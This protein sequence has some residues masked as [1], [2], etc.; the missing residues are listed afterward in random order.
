SNG[1]A[2]FLAK[3]GLNP[4]WAGPCPSRNPCSKLSARTAYAASSG[5]QRPL[6]K[7]RGRDRAGGVAV[8]Q[9]V[10]CQAPS[11]AE[12]LVSYPRAAVPGGKHH[13]YFP[14]THE[15]EGG[16]TCSQWLTTL[17]GDSPTPSLAQPG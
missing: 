14:R 17:T 4:T 1:A 7:G 8:R 16:L 12:A 3:G 9:R 15:V 6:T 13:G 10:L 11:R 5:R 2:S